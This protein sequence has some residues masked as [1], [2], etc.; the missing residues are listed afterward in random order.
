MWGSSLDIWIKGPRSSASALPTLMHRSSNGSRWE[1]TPT[2]W[3]NP[4][5]S[6]GHFGFLMTVTYNKW[7][8]DDIWHFQLNSML[9]L[10][11]TQTELQ[12]Q[13]F[14]FFSIAF[15]SGYTDGHS[16]IFWIQP[17][18]WYAW[19]HCPAERCS[20]LTYVWRFPME[21]NVLLI[22]ND[23]QTN[24]AWFAN[25]IHHSQNNAFLFFFATKKP[26]YQANSMFYTLKHTKELYGYFNSI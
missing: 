18:L 13:Y 4:R 10:M 1:S 19:D 17:L 3:L 7:H 24:S 16:R 15:K 9:G 21:K 26:T 2:Y 12:Q 11:D 22:P 6:K 5:S 23:S 25:T 8:F 14:F 20:F